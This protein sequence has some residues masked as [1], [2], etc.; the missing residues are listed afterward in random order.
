MATQKT[1]SPYSKKLSPALVGKRH[2]LS[3]FTLVEL[4]VVISIL[5][6][7]GTIGFISIQGYTR[8]TRDSNR[9]SDINSAMKSLELNQ[10]KSGSYPSPDSSF[11]V[12]YSGWAVWNQGVFGAGVLT[13]LSWVGIN[14]APVDPLTQ[15]YYTYSL[16]AYGNAYQIQANYEGDSL[17]YWPSFVDT[18]YAASGNPDRYP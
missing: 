6:I 9:V 14:K 12:T 7:L 1:T 18:A 8:N 17:S 16:L 11:A 5:A 10:I 4:I 13:R 3:G 15:S 2:W